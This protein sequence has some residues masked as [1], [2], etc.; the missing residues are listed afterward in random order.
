MK[1]RAWRHVINQAGAKPHE[2]AFNAVDASSSPPIIPLP[3]FT[4]PSPS[5]STH[6][7]LSFSFARGAAAWCNTYVHEPSNPQAP[8]SN[9][10][11]RGWWHFV[12]FN[13]RPP[14]ILACRLLPDLPIGSFTL[15]TALFVPLRICVH[16]NAAEH[17]PARTATNVCGRT[18]SS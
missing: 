7:T 12:T 5:I 13:Q 6:P 15:H 14:T 8:L 9:D 10:T 2:V 3:T 18:S 1:C 17:W 16:G 4:F 11:R